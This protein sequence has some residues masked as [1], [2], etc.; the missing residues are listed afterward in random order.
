M[1]KKITFF[2]SLQN[3]TP[4]AK[5]QTWKRRRMKTNKQKYSSS[6]VAYKINKDTMELIF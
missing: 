4:A 1:D 3:F 5:H 2:L 6:I